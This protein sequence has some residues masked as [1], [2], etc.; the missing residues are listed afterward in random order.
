MSRIAAFLLLFFCALAA[1]ASERE[2]SFAGL[3]YSQRGVLKIGDT[4]T[5]VTIYV[6]SFPDKTA[7]QMEAQAGMLCRIE[8]DAKDAP[9]L[10][11]VG[12]FFK[13]HWAKE[14]VLRDFIAIAGRT[15]AVRT[16]AVRAEKV[17]IFTPD[18]DVRILYSNFSLEKKLDLILPRKIEIASEDYSLSLNLLTVKK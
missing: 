14:S 8:I 15:S 12:G 6:R 17:C 18:G 10:V 3:T 2:L 11:E 16:K 1:S 7:M 13:E 9:T 4:E 5:P